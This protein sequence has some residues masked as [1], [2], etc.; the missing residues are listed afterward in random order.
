MEQC[1]CMDP[2]HLGA[3][4]H[5]SEQ[6]WTVYWLHAWLRERGSVGCRNGVGHYGLRERLAFHFFLIRHVN[7]VLLVLCLVS[8]LSHLCL[9]VSVFLPCHHSHMYWCKNHSHVV[10]YEI[11]L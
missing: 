11:E 9:S 3:V 6:R 10:C 1:E 2:S 7:E 4:I 5:L 8:F